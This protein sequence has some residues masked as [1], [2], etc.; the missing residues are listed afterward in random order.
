MAPRTPQEAVNWGLNQISG[1]AQW[2][3]L[4]ERF[5]TRAYGYTG[6]FPSAIAHWVAG[7]NKH[8]DKNPPLGALAFFAP[9]HTV[10][11]LGDGTCLSN[12]IGGA[13]KISRVPLSEVYNGRW[14]LHYLGWLGPESFNGVG[15]GRMPDVNKKLPNLIDVYARPGSVNTPIDLSADVP[16]GV[17]NQDASPRSSTPIGTILTKF[18][19]PQ[20][21]VRVGIFALAI[22]CIV[23]SV[24]ILLRKPIGSTVEALA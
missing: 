24:F 10:L 2:D 4:C 23:A 16:V 14:H 21:W 1:P 12:D 19:T 9:N 11:C 8:Y 18:S 22:G 20:F 6:G 3:H 5:T 15:S 13:G 7:K 17:T